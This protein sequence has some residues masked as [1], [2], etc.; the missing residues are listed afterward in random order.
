MKDIINW[1]ISDELNEDPIL[2]WLNVNGNHI[3]LN[4]HNN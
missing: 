2:G 1:S 4:K 3:E